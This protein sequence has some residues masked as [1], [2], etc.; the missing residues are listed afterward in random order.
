VLTAEHLAHL[1]VRDA[2]VE[3][4]GLGDA[5]GERVRIA[6]D[7]QLEEDIGVVELAALALP[8]VEPRRQLRALALDLLRPLVVVPEI[9]LANLLV[10][11]FE[12]RFRSGNVKD[13]PE[14]S[15]AGARGPSNALSARW[16]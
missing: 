10:E 12:A 16:W 7:G 9:R 14:A 15:R 5:L 1:E 8:A 11:N 2:R 6:F 13:A 4:V 3:G